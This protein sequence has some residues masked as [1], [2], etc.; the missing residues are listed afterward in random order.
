LAQLTFQ[1]LSHLQQ[2]QGQHFG[3]VLK[4]FQSVPVQEQEGLLLYQ[5]CKGGYEE[6]L[7]IYLDLKISAFK[8]LF[9]T[10]QDHQEY[11]SLSL[12]VHLPNHYTVQQTNALDE[13]HHAVS[14]EGVNFEKQKKTMMMAA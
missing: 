5:A 14:M 12:F 7:R 4:R 3:G 2:E 6:N 9:L 10:L 8:C 1:I 13:Q 11:A